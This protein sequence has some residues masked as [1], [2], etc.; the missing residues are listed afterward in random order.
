[1]SGTVTNVV[2]VGV[3]LFQFNEEGKRVGWTLQDA[4]REVST[5]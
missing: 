1:M 4:S 3:M 5:I 2:V